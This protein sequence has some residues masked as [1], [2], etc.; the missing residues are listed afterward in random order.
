MANYFS[1]P[2]EIRQI[3]L[4]HAIAA[5]HILDEKNLSRIVQLQSNFA[6][7]G[8]K[9]LL[10]LERLHLYIDNSSQL[11]YGSRLIIRIGVPGIS[12]STTE[13][14]ASHLSIYLQARKLVIANPEISGDLIWVLNTW[15]E[16]QTEWDLWWREQMLKQ[17]AAV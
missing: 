14:L 2:L 12:S 17:I 1:L 10:L 13:N 8:L 5:A 15:A 16:T 6:G 7:S 11:Y 9:T 4:A 3:I